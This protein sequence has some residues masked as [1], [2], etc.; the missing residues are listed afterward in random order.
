MLLVFLLGD[1]HLKAPLAVTSPL[2]LPTVDGQSYLMEGAQASQ[3][4]TADPTGKL[5]FHR[6]ARRRK[7]NAWSGIR[8]GEL[9]VE[10]IRESIEK[11]RPP[12]DDDV[13]EEMRPY[14]YVDGVERGLD[15]RG[16]RL[17]RRRRRVLGR[18]SSNSGQ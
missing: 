3:D 17:V 18:L 5:T 11:R 4:T 2:T 9:G 1:P 6:V 15:E 12:G 10:P 8:L 16:K 13:A 14:I 7:S